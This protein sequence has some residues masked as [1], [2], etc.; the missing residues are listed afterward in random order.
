VLEAIRAELA[1]IARYPDAGGFELKQALARRHQVSP[2]CITL[3]NGSNDVLVLLAEAFLQDCLE[4]VYSRYSFAV[5]MLAVQAVGAVARVAPA[6]PADRPQ[7]LGHDLDAMARLAGRKTRLVFIANPNNPTGTWVRSE[8]LRAFLDAMSRDTLVVVDQ[9]Y[10]EYMVDP[11]Y[12]DCATWLADYPNLVVTQTFSKAFGLAGLRV[13][14][15]LSHPQVAEVLNRVR[16]PFNVNSLAS[17]AALAALEDTA[18]LERSVTI[19]N[20]ER[21]RLETACDRLGLRYVPSGGNFVLIDMG[22]PARPR[23]E[24][25]LRRS[26]IV[27]PVDNYGLPNHLRISVGTP[28]ENARLIAALE[29][30]V[31]G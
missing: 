11:D 26:I 22:A 16:Q 12:P 1:D 7:P 28:D 8:P 6:N 19:N 27:R 29:D 9:A 17:V 21:A 25:L 4:A 20:S 24:A 23:Y 14:Y 31:A 3:G 15:C 5:Y 2:D 10:R 18:H 13:G 30:V